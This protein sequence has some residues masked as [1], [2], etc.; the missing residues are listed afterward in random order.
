[1]LYGF[2]KEDIKQLDKENPLYIQARY[3]QKIGKYCEMDLN[4][5]IVIDNVGNAISIDNELI[6]LRCTCD[7]LNQGIR[8]YK[9]KGAN[10]FEKY[11]DIQ[12]I[13]NWFYYGEIYNRI[14]IEVDYNKLKTKSAER[15]KLLDFISKYSIIFIKSKH[16]GFSCAVSVNIL[17]EK[18]KAFIE[19][20]SQQCAIWGEKLLI[21]EYLNVKKDSLGKRE[22]RHIVINGEV[23]N[24]SRQTISLLHTVPKSHVKKAEEKAGIIKKI[25]GFPVNYVLDLCEFF[26]DEEKYIDV[27]EINPLTTSTCFINNSIFFD[28]EISVIRHKE[29][30]LGMGLEY[31]MDYTEKTYKYINNRTSNGEYNYLSEDFYEFL[32]I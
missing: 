6:M 15:R 19:F 7:N 29:E 28:K 21:C 17:L 5:K 3:A 32:S 18:R 2:I 27:V 25:K 30:I 14:I 26:V 23:I 4:K 1:M 9:E 31:Y 12:K 8:I 22:S 10:L 11:E 24:S 13:E 16:K 20:L